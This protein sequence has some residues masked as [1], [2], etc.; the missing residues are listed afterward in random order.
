MGARL[1]F[2]QVKYIITAKGRVKGFSKILLKK[3]KTPDNSSRLLPKRRE[4][5]AEFHCIKIVFLPYLSILTTL[6]TRLSFAQLPPLS[7]LKPSPTLAENE[8]AQTAPALV[9]VYNL[10]ES[11]ASAYESP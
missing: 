2:L 10:T 3:K 6:S 4:S 5:H 8:L 9:Q 7:F 11:A 1:P